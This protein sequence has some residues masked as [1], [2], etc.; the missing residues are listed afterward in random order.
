MVR[1]S[2]FQAGNL[3]SIPSIPTSHKQFVNP[4]KGQDG[5]KASLNA[6]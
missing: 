1:T 2:A 3:G 5:N 6:I 4:E